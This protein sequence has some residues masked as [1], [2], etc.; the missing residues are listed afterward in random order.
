GGRA[1]D[2]AF[3]HRFDQARLGV[4]RRRGGL[5]PFGG[6][7]VGDDGVTLLQGRQAGVVAAGVVPVRV[8]AFLV[9]GQEAAEGDD[10][11]G[12]GQ[13]GAGGV[14]VGEDRVSTEADRGGRTTGIGHL[15][16]DR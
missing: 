16:G 9:G 15:R 4:S 13:F 2:A 1:A 10:G 8:P 12:G 5:M 11:A 6:H 14:A 3:L 7:L